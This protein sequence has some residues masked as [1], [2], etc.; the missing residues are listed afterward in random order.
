MVYLVF[1]FFEYRDFLM[2][3]KLEEYNRDIYA[4][5]PDK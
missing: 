4:F 3:N 1:F 2:T 5:F